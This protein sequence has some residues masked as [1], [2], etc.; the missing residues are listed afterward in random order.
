M[1]SL[2]K[3]AQYAIREKFQK[4]NNLSYVLKT[5][6]LITEFKPFLNK[7]D[8]LLINLQKSSIWM[9]Q[10]LNRNMLTLSKIFKILCTFS[11]KC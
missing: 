10:N 5:A 3:F 6:V 11:Q 8:I 4:L 2:Q 1:Y 7:E 9:F